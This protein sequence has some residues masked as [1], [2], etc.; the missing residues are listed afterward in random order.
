MHYIC[1]DNHQTSL[2][3]ETVRRRNSHHGTHGSSLRCLHR[4]GL[5]NPR[6]VRVHPSVINQAGVQTPAINLS[7]MKAIYSHTTT[8]GEQF[9]GPIFNGDLEGL[10]GNEQML[11]EQ[12]HHDNLVMLQEEHGDNFVSVEY[13]CDERGFICP[14][15]LTRLLS[16]CAEVKVY[17]MVKDGTPPPRKRGIMNMDGTVE[18]FDGEY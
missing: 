6:H 16:Q 11:L 13:A 7:A 9:L 2:S 8:I 4:N 12:E 5:R 18:K 3:Y 14:C 15:E 17:A 1:A 10:S